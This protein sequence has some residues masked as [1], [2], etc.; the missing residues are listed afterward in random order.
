MNKPS[1]EPLKDPKYCNRCRGDLERGY[2]T[3]YSDPREYICIKCNK[4]EMLENWKEDGNLTTSLMI[5]AAIQGV[6]SEY[7]N[8]S[9]Y[10]IEAFDIDDRYDDIIKATNNINE[11]VHG[12][13]KQVWFD[14]MKSLVKACDTKGMSSHPDGVKI[15]AWEG[16]GRCVVTLEDAVASITLIIGADY[17]ES[18]KT[19]DISPIPE[20]MMGIQGISATEDEAISLLDYAIQLWKDGDINLQSDKEVSVW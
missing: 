16:M 8:K 19:Y 17:P 18:Y 7:D 10:G 11:K 3:I 5:D 9:N 13:E 2:T 14:G 15:L 12:F 6:R 20:Y 4:A 1:A